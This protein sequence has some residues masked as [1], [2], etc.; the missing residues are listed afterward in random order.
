MNPDEVGHYLEG[1]IEYDARNGLI[2]EQ[3]HWPNGSVVYQ[4]V[5]D[6]S[7]CPFPLR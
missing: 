5:G 6:F 3:Y 1:D 2:D 7:K 4:I